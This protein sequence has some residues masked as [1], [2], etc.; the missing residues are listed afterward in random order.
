MEYDLG[1][2]VPLGTTITDANGIAANADSVTC[3]IYQPDGSTATGTV[4]STGT[5]IYNCDFIPTMV[6]RFVVRWVAVGANQGAIEDEFQV[7]DINQLGIVSL[8]L[9]RLH[10]NLVSTKNDTEIRRFM[11]AATSQAERYMNRVIGRRSFTESYDGGCYSIL[12]R[13]GTILSITSVTENGVVNSPS[14]YLVDEYGFAIERI[15][16]Q[17]F[18][19]AFP[20]RLG[21]S[22]TYVAGFANPPSDLVQGVLELIR[23]LWDTQ[24]GP[25]SVMAADTN[26]GYVTGA[27][28]SLP[29]K[30]AESFDNWRLPTTA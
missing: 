25:V 4:V 27:G 30:V 1:S 26:E 20:Q 10:L 3:L 7:R 16:Q 9:V 2:R 23:H 28:Y 17:M 6:G 8:D 24:R 5:G 21:V 29:H 15:D 12:T 19:P 18:A 14:L 11:G 22:I 13:H